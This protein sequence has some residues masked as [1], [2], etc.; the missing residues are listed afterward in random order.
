MAGEDRHGIARPEMRHPAQHWVAFGD[1]GQIAIGQLRLGGPARPILSQPF[2]AAL[3]QRIRHR[4][5]AQHQWHRR[6]VAAT[7]PLPLSATAKPLLSLICSDL[8]N[9]RYRYVTAIRYRQT[10]EKLI[11]IPCSNEI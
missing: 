3:A 1:F 2:L 5:G 9:I 6:P 7:G 10:V 4:Q 8:P 11:F